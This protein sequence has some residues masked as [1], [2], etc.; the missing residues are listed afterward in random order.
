[1]QM[2]AM[3]RLILR[4]LPYVLVIVG[5]LTIT[6]LHAFPEILAPLGVIAAGIVLGRI[7]NART[8]R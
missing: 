8:R 3:A 5:F 4:N 7:R 1:M 6:K 2:I